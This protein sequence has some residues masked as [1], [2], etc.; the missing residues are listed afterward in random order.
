MI[1]IDDCAFCKHNKHVKIDGWIPTCDAYPEGMPKHMNDCNMH[2]IKECNNGIGFEPRN[3]E[4][5]Q[6]WLRRTHRESFVG[7]QVRLFL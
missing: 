3:E 4:E 2:I 1:Y 7:K 5:W 6:D